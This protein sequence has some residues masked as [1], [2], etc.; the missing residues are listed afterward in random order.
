[1]FDSTCPPS[2]EIAI[3]AFALSFP[4]LDILGHAA[5]YSPICGAGHWGEVIKKSGKLMT[6]K[7]MQAEL[8][9][10]F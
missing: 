7:D 2:L 8:R 6:G 1:M 9:K 5:P 10:A 3:V 4:W